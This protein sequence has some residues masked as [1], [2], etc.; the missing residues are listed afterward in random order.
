MGASDVDYEKMLGADDSGLLD[1]AVNAVK[2]VVGKVADKLD[3]LTER[4]AGLFKTGLRTP[5]TRKP[6]NGLVAISTV[7]HP[8]SPGRLP[9]LHDL[10]SGYC[11][12]FRVR[13]LDLLG[14]NIL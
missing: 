11:P 1:T 10:Q 6:S 5:V 14:A 2:G 13:V 8:F 12:T 3:P 7:L 4:Y 9:E